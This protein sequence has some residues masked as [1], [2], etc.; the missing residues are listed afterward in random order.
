MD[1][2]WAAMVAA[3]AAGV[4]GIGG[5]WIGF[6]GGRRQTT[7]QAQVEHQQWLRGQRQEAYTEYLSTWDASLI[8]LD[9][10]IVSLRTRLDPA[11]YTEGQ[12][13][14][15]RG[16]YFATQIGEVMRPVRGRL[17]RVQLL[18]P[19]A[20]S[21]AAKRLSD[22]LDEIVTEVAGYGMRTSTTEEVD[23]RAAAFFH[24]TIGLLELR[25]QFFFEAR[26]VLM[27]APALK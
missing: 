10:V 27:A 5:A 4:F 18:G 9:E 6:L 11:T 23:E 17:E 2:G 8:T 12:F 15:Q 19:D 24:R 25:E 14:Q 13:N 7:D 1:Q 26:K 22:A 3:V 16:S 20:T 21:T